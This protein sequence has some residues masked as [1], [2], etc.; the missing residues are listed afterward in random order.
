MPADDPSSLPDRT[1][2]RHLM[3]VL[4]RVLAFARPYRW[5]LAGA[6]A[7]TLLASIVW[8]V[9]P[10]GLRALLDAVF[11]AGD[12]AL[13]DRLAL[14]LLGLFLLQALLNFVGGYGLEWTGE[15]V[16]AD[17][18]HALY[19]HLHRLGLRFYAEGRVGEITSRLTNDVATI[20]S[21]VTEHL[22][23]L[24]TQS[25]SLVGSAALMLVLNWRL[26]VIV[27]V[28]APVVSLVSRH[29]GRIVRRLARQ[30]QD[31][32]ADT[33]AIAEETLS[34]VR[35]VK[36]FAREPYEVERYG[37]AVEELFGAA[38]K[39][40]LISAAFWSGVG[41]LFLVAL[42]AIF[43]TG[44]TEVLAGRLTAGDLVAFIFY[45][46]TIAQ[47]VG[48][49]AQ[50]YTAYNTVAGASERLFDL[51]D[52][53]P[54]IE[55]APGAPPIRRVAGH[56]RFEDVTFGYDPERPVLRDVSFEAE[57]G[58]TVALVG[59]SGAGKTTLMHLLPRFYDPDRGRIF[60][61]G[62]DV[63]T[64]DVASLR[65]RFGLVAQDVQLFGTT[66]AE[67]IRYGRL[68][69]TEAEIRAA[70]EAANALDF[71]EALPLGF[72][73]PVGE[74]G[75]KLSGGQRQR[76]SI[77]RAILTN[78]RLLLLDEATSA[79]DAES[80]ALVQEAFGRLLA[81]RTAFVIAH[82]L[83]TVRHADRILVLEAGRIVED[84]THDELIAAGRLYAR[85]AE[86]QFR[87]A[88]ST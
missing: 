6:L 73:T 69:A 67:N 30:I 23:R 62:Q 83:A 49:L 87:E 36:A 11:E 40:A 42:V 65:A 22:A 74:R 44:G 53:Q 78:P 41:L 8:L 35:V 32:L 46:M 56:V 85:L 59:P 70:A 80:E 68:D 26:A 10:L 1:A 7:L 76:L 54:E 48:S 14:G 82:R 25:L 17:L 77:A 37:S 24:V 9:V 61:D 60:L 63:R 43:W 72:S 3:T 88:V 58:Q 66:V 19:Q 45:A 21:A 13:L 57:P 28:V 33:T 51:L 55:S 86:L 18:R 27:F 52:M 75:V 29:F 39:R 64:V 47:S 50:L 34:A 20:R 81:G 15:R 12:R 84:G 79:L 16:V 5:R 71:I 38:R 31:R 4:R 2:E